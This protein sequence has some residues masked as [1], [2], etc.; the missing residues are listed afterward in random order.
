MN[1]VAAMLLN[2]LVRGASDTSR[3][4]YLC[5]I[6]DSVESIIISSTVRN[7]ASRIFHIP[8]RFNIRP[9]KLGHEVY[10]YI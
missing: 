8:T 10:F 6:L 9:T 7:H 3:S 2:G 1:I 5:I 4:L